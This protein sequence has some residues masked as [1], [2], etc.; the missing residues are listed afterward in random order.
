MVR[1]S[2]REQLLRQLAALR[3]VAVQISLY[4]FT[5]P[6]RASRAMRYAQNLM[7]I[8]ALVQE[9]R[10]LEPR[11]KLLKNTSALQILPCLSVEEFVQEMRVCQD[12]FA[13][14]L[15]EIEGKAH[16]K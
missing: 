15:S 3:S 5:N 16:C 4:R 13:F 6:E 12:T 9:N 10:Y 1:F 7:S 11:R 2:E 14:I 8:I